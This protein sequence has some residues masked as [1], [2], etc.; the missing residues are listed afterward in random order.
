MKILFIHQNFPGQFKHLAIH[1]ARH[2]DDQIW[3]ITKRNKNNIP[4]VRKIVYDIK[5]KS[6]KSTHRFVKDL[7]NGVIHGEEVADKCVLMRK[8]G[9]VPDIVV[10]HPGWG[11]SLFIKDVF[12]EVPL[13]NYFEY[14]FHGNSGDIG[15]DPAYPSTLEDFKRIRI[16]NSLL[17][18]SLEECDWGITPTRWQWQQHPEH[19][20]H[21]ISIIHEGVDTQL[22][23]PARENFSLTMP[24]GRTL[25]RNDEVITY[26]SRN[27]E[28]YRGFP[29]FM[30]ALEI[31]L[32]RRP[33]AVAIVVGGNEVS[34]GQHLP[35]GQTYRDVM[36]DQ[37]DIDRERVYFTGR[38]PYNRYLS[39]LRISAAHIYLT[40][41]FVLS[42]S[43]LEAM[44][45]GCL[46]I[47]SATPP[48]Q[49]LLQHDKNGLL[50]DFFSPEAIADQVDRVMTHP[51]QMARLRQA[52]RRTIVEG[53]DLKRVALP[54]QIRLI[55]LIAAG[56]IPN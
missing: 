33:K 20:R 29:S 24:D 46:V 13:L 7:E 35:Q 17:Q 6:G 3:F 2:A 8:K 21:K 52:A 28:P 44:A 42:W 49:E 51:D 22:L 54:R 30:R 50:V 45:T 38:I 41:P 55:E 9:M 5:R 56:V 39:V 14:Y 32:K 40:I 23:K 27:L 47:G 36:L 31:I 4:N 43:M 10:A 48:V 19:Y 53:Y 18:L 34:Y 12:P 37:V 16:R 15:F 1:Y 11:E 25:T 26:V